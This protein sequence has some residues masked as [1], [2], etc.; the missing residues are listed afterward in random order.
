MIFGRVIQSSEEHLSGIRKRAAAPFASPLGSVL[1][2]KPKLRGRRFKL[3]VSIRL[4]Y[5]VSS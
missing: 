2:P 5:S 1:G 4:G 3:G